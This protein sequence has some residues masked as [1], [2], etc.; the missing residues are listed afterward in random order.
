VGEHCIP[1]SQ[2]CDRHNDCGNNAD[3]DTQ[4]CQHLN[5]SFD[6][7][8]WFLLRNT[9]LALIMLSQA[10]IVPKQLNAGSGLNSKSKVRQGHWQLPVPLMELIFAG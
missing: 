7:T 4:L 2:T 10:G 1:L 9:M 6:I 8:L 5:G 3:E